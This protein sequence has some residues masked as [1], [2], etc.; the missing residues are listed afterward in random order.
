M[1]SPLSPE[2]NFT[3]AV[4]LHIDPLRWARQVGNS[5][6]RVLFFWT[7][8][9]F[10]VVLGYILFGKAIIALGAFYLVLPMMYIYAIFRLIKIID[11]QNDSQKKNT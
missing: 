1:L 9:L 3:G 7:C 6:I 10:F 5:W 11:Q 4:P 8:Q 2:R